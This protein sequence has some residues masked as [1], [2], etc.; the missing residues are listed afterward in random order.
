MR[1]RAVETGVL[2]TTVDGRLVIASPTVIAGP[3]ATLAMSDMV[4]IPT[5]RESRITGIPWERLAWSR[6]ITTGTGSSGPQVTGLVSITD[7]TVIV[8]R[9]ST[10]PARRTLIPLCLSTME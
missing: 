4:I 1:S 8:S 9:R 2:G 10:S 6:S 3:P 7:P 5:S